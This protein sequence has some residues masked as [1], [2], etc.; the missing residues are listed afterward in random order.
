MLST[1]A[2]FDF[3][4]VQSLVAEMLTVRRATETDV[5]INNLQVIYAQI[6]QAT[7]S[8]L[9]I[10]AADGNYYHLDVLDGNVIPTQV[11]PTEAEINASE[12]EDGKQI[13]VTNISEKNLSATTIRGVYGLINQITANMISVT[14]LVATNAFITYLQTANLSTNSSLR[15][16]VGA[17]NNV[18]EWFTFDVAHGLT[19]QR[20]AYTDEDGVEHAASPWSTSTTETGFHI[21][22]EGAID[23]IGSFE[24]DQLVT[25]GVQVGEIVVRKTES[26]GWYWTD[27]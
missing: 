19:I 26:G 22:K 6:V 4:T 2:T 10:K 24:K 14:D 25:Q 15:I 16:A 7:V 9:I 17:A 5:F 11:T 21:L 3:A 18:N 20:P 12:M 23:P 27:A 8:D 13:V 1:K